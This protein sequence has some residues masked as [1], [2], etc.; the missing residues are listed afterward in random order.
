MGKAMSLAFRTVARDSVWK[1]LTW[2]GRRHSGR[3]FIKRGSTLNS[4]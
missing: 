4:S 1:E 2:E 3:K